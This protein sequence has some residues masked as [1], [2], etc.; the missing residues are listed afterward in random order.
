[1]S[2]KHNRSRFL[3][4]RRRGQIVLVLAVVAVAL[5]VVVGVTSQGRSNTA[6]STA[7]GSGTATASNSAPPA[8]ELARRI[9][10]DPTALGALK[11]PV[12]LIE[13][14]DYRCPFCGIF[15]R[16]TMPKLV[17]EYVKSGV[18]R[19]EWRDFVIYGQQ[20]LD[21]AVAARAA[22][23]QGLFWKYHDAIYAAAPERAHSALPRKRLREIA[24]SVGVPDMAKFER[25][26][27]SSTFLGLVNADTKEGASIGV[28]GTPSF[29]V[30]N[31]TIV[32][33]QPI[34]VFRQ[35]IESALAEARK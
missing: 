19:I 13:Y 34:D 22:G 18:L 24:K 6:Q 29:V 20:S 21:A 33:A 5:F 9:A 11:A 2:S 25:D 27:R 3:P 26:M 32:G 30:N 35:A 10:G 23:E 8:L 14:A 1:M 31:T 28:T 16:D 7:A 4:S 17:D 15:A 12:V